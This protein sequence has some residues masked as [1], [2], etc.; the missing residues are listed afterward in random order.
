[1][2]YFRGREQAEALARDYAARG[3]RQS[4]DVENA[5]QLK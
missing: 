4:H 2:W 5:L 1:M 3:H